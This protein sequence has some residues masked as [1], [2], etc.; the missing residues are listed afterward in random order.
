MQDSSLNQHANFGR[1]TWLR[2]C[3]YDLIK[4]TFNNPSGT[5]DKEQQKKN[6]DKED[7]NKVHFDKD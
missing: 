2:D 1:L 3:T 7:I 6:V 5:N 4:M